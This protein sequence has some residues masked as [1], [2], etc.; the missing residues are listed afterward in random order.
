MDT[1]ENRGVGSPGSLQYTY[2]TVV[3]IEP[4]ESLELADTLRVRGHA[5]AAEQVGT[6]V[7]RAGALRRKVA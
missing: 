4:A 6:N 7:V 2:K 3:G 5:L 1:R